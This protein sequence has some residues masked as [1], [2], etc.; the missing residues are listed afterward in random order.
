MA[1]STNT[2][3]T[4]E[5]AIGLIDD[6]ISVARMG[7]TPIADHYPLPAD[8]EIN[9]NPESLTGE[10]AVPAEKLFTLLARSSSFHQTKA[11]V[12][13]GAN[14]KLP[15]GFKDKLKENKESREKIIDDHRDKTTQI[16]KDY[17]EKLKKDK[18][19]DE[20]DAINQIDQA[21]KDA[22]KKDGEKIDQIGEDAKDAIRGVD[23]GS[24]DWHAV[25]G[26]IVAAT[27]SVLDFFSN[28]WNQIVEFAKKVFNE[29][30]KAIEAA[31]QWFK[32]RWEDVK[33]AILDFGKNIFG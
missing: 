10:P 7:Y 22:K 13:S 33:R 18:N 16:V 27:K 21:T 14:S 12:F 3:S 28:L 32:D 6:L 20:E 9:T 8:L 4:T 2:I 17:G 24:S 25:V 19:A 31:I 29:I 15:P 30:K 26:E 23:K 1:V 11:S 5:D